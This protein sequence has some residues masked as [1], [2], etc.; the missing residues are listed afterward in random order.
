MSCDHLPDAVG[1]DDT[2]KEDEWDEMAMQDVRLQRKIGHH[3]DPGQEKGNQTNESIAAAVTTGTASLDDI[4]GGFEG[5]ENQDDGALNQVPLGEAEVV[6][7]VGYGDGTGEESLRQAKG[8]QKRLLPD[9]AAAH[10]TSQGVDTDKDQ[11][12]LNRPIDNAKRQ[13]LGVVLIPSLY[14]EGH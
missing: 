2:S 1:V 14:V 9:V 4:L 11:Y 7:E 6:K 3:E 5:V 13:G 8:R 12:T 10:I